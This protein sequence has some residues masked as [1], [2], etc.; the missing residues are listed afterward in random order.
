MRQTDTEILFNHCSSHIKTVG[1]EGPVSSEHNQKKKNP[2]LPFSPRTTAMDQKTKQQTKKNN[3]VSQ[4][5]FHG[6]YASEKNYDCSFYEL[7]CMGEGEKEK[8]LFK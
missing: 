4:R 8:I 6:N 1:A 3:L 2:S 5:T 7:T